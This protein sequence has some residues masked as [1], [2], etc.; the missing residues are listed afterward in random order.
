MHNAAE[1][2]RVRL[3]RRIDDHRALIMLTVLFAV[4]SVTA[5]NFLNVYN[6]TTILEAATLNGI[7]AIGFTVV[8]ILGQLDLS[9][10]AV[11]MFAGMLVIGLQLVPS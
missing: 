3:L 6:V 9:I 10:G 2:K 7:V 8:F 11:V 5:S 1:L 4:L